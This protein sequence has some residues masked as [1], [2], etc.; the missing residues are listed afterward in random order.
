M[1]SATSSSPTLKA[2]AQ[3]NQA[4]VREY[5]SYQSLSVDPYAS[6]RTATIA[7]VIIIFSG[8][9]TIRT[10]VKFGPNAGFGPKTNSDQNFKFGQKYSSN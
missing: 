6:P 4:Q 9:T 10:N 3:I 1:T 8:C 5:V 2:G 7:P